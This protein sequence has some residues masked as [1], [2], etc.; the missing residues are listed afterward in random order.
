MAVK[1]K[2]DNEDE[3]SEAIQVTTVESPSENFVVTEH[4]Q[5]M[6]KIYS[7]GLIYLIVIILNVA[8]IYSL[9][10][11]ID[12]VSECSTVA[13][14]SSHKIKILSDREGYLEQIF[15]SEGYKIEKN[16]PL[17]LIR[18]KEALTYRSKVSELLSSIPLKR[19]YY[20]IKISAARD[21]LRQLEAGNN[22]TLLVKNL[23]LEQNSI[24]L[25][26]IENDF[27]HWKKEVS[28]LSTEYDNTKILYEEGI[29]T[30]K[31]YH[32]IELRL[33]KARTEVQGLISK[34]NINLKE[35]LIIEEE[36]HDTKTNYKSRKKIREKEIKELELEQETTLHS[37]QNELMMYE[38]KMQLMG[39][40]S[41]N[42]DDVRENGNT[43]LAGNAGTI[44]ELYFRNTG[45]Y[46]RVS[47]LLC[48]IVPA[49]R[50]LYM[51]ITVANRDIGFIEDGMKIKYKFDAF[52]YS[53]YGLLYGNVSSIS[54]SAIEDKTNEFIYHAKGTLDKGFFEIR[55]KEYKIKAGMTATA[56]VVTEKKT[57]FSFLFRRVKGKF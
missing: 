1:E 12:V 20:K 30:I 8:L 24:S 31:E 38:Q 21:A 3:Q 56:E 27:E 33:D 41:T 18:S 36:I 23:K 22:N 55:G 49:G 25:A 13:R 54:P 39:G 46:I 9:L 19:D 57:I 17:F 37:M 48:T 34:K 44:S 14:P 40:D 28:S 2:E 45:D 7:R 35:K 52:P 51:D 6:P 16:A 43:V 11:K 47:D 42:P 4:L 50:T 32:E 15:I 26:S 5:R 29:S 53:D 10:S